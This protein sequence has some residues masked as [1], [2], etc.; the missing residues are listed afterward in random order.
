MTWDQLNDFAQR[1]GRTFAAAFL[2]QLSISM[3]G[4][5]DTTAARAAVVAAGVAGVNAV[6]LA[7]QQWLPGPSPKL[8]TPEA[9]Q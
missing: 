5:V 2:G 4:V 3:L 1:I 9:D 8:G 6:I 7:A